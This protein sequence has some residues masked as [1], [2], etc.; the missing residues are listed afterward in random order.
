MLPRGS[1]L[2][3]PGGPSRGLGGGCRGHGS[4]RRWVSITSVSVGRQSRRD[5]RH[6]RLGFLAILVRRRRCQ[7]TTQSTVDA[8]QQGKRL[9]AA[10]VGEVVEVDGPGGRATETVVQHELALVHD[11]LRVVETDILVLVVGARSC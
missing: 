7:Q 3:G 5:R 2:L 10:P 9:L 1:G 11:A 4:G 8:A 6:R